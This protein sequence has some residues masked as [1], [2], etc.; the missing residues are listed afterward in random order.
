MPAGRVGRFLRDDCSSGQVN[1]IS[2]DPYVTE[3]TVGPLTI[4]LTQT[5]GAISQRTSSLTQTYEISNASGSR[6][7]W[8]SR[9]TWTA[10]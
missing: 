7:T 5:V 9:G 1:Q 8:R 2:A 4:R 3:I 6:P 10:I